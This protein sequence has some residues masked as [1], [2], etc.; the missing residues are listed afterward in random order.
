MYQYRENALDFEWNDTN[1]ENIDKII[2]RENV[3][4]HKI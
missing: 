2:G 4:A 3:A 1:H